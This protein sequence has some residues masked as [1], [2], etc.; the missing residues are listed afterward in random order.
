ML[1]MAIYKDYYPPKF[2]HHAKFQ[3]YHIDHCIDIIRQ[4][5]QCHADLTVIPTKWYDGLGRDFIDSD[6][7]HTCRNFEKVRQWNLDNFEKSGS[8]VLIKEEHPAPP[9]HEWAFEA[10]MR[11]KGYAPR[12]NQ[13]HHAH[14]LK[15]DVATGRKGID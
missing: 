2:G 14:P 10:Y 4:S 1:R 12:Q 6:Q 7:T 11:R 9:G 3:E 15:E 8:D 13:Y 5:I